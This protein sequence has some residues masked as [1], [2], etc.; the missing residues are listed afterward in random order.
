MRCDVSA[1]AS[2]AKPAA[3]CVASAH[4]LA[5]AVS[6]EEAQYSSSLCARRAALVAVCVD[7][8]K[9]SCSGGRLLSLACR[10]GAT[11]LPPPP[12]PSRL[13]R[14]KQE[15]TRWLQLSLGSDVASL[16]L[17]GRA[18]RAALDVASLGP[19]EERRTGG[20]LL[21]LASC[22]G[23]TFLTAASNAKP[24]AACEGSA[25]APLLAFSRKETQHSS[26]LRTR[27]AP[28]WAW[29]A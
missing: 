29:L 7:P 16:K 3:A 24:A 25:R 2:T 11:C 9:E 28:R 13:P 17:A 4:A 19:I 14:E 26:L 10:R 12:K 6:E 5:L 1:A 18:R 27:S 22:R 8:T 23:L 15:H 20:R 21:L